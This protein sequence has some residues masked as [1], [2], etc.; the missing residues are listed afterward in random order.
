M[1]MTVSDENIS[2][3]FLLRHVLHAGRMMNSA[4]VA[5]RLWGQLRGLQL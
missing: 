3:N 2:T 1:E 5:R 4:S